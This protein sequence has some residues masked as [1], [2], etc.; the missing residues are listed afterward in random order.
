MLFTKTQIK[1]LKL[2][3]STLTRSYSIRSIS[4]IIGQSYPLTYHS[5]KDLIKKGFIIEDEHRLL[6]LNYKSNFQDLAYIESLRAEEFL[7]K[8]KDIMVFVDELIGKMEGFF[9]LLVFGSYADGKETRNSDVDI[10]MII[11]KTED[12]DKEERFLSRIADLYLKRNHPIVIGK[13]SVK[14]M[15]RE[16]DKLNVINET[17]NKHI[18]FFGADDYYRLVKER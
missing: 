7:R 6:S 5:T 8:H 17:L 18:I 9:A 11:E 16:R 3:C 14:E 2:L 10:L 15:I 13:E 12:A 4:Q 1:I